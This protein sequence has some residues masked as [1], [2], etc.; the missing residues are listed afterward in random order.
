M[1]DGAAPGYAGIQLRSSVRGRHRLWIAGLYRNAQLERELRQRLG[2]TAPKHSLTA[3]LITGTLLVCT[4]EALDPN[5]LISQIETVLHDFSR[6]TGTPLFE[7]ERRG[8]QRPVHLSLELPARRH[9]GHARLRNGSE[10]L[11]RGRTLDR[12]RSPA[13]NGKNGHAANGHAESASLLDKLLRRARQAAASA[14]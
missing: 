6:Q 13:A 1:N 8:R 7:L 4:D 12:R 10:A 2:A 9:A 3:N 14:R 5:G 11:A